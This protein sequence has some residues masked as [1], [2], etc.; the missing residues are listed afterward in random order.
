MTAVALDLSYIVRMFVCTFAIIVL[1]KVM[2]RFQS[3]Q[4]FASPFRGTPTSSSRPARST[5]VNGD[6]LLTSM[7][8]YGEYSHVLGL[9]LFD[10]DFI[11]GPS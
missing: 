5:W 2:Y 7:L 4:R 3:L 1:T 9:H 10:F 11:E 8:F 6:T